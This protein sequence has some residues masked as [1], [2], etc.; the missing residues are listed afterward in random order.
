MRYEGTIY[1]PPGERHSY[2][3]QATVGCS[4]NGCTFCHM[5]KDK[6]YHVRPLADILEDIKLASIYYGDIPRVFICDGDAMDIPTEDL[7]T[8]LN[9]LYAAFPS[10]H[11]V[12]IYAS[13]GSALNKTPDELRKLREAGITRVYIGVESGS[14][15]VLKAVHKGVNAEEMLEAG[16]RLR[17]AGFDLW[18]MIL[19]GLAGTGEAGEKHALASAEIINKMQPRHLS[20]LSLVVE[21]GTVLWRQCQSGEFVCAAP[22]EILG[23][24]R[25]MVE[26]LTVDP[27]HFTCDHASNYLPLKGTLPDER[28]TFLHAL[29]EALSGNVKIRPEWSRGV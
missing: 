7:L 16:I 17:T 8:I 6:R 24:V 23:E 4:H 14:D 5:Y 3:L 27:L 26:N 19:L 29:N 18:A 13:P 21:E 20:L 10:L 2:L 12:G 11:K 25:A 1:R 28:E 22:E 9:T 15:E